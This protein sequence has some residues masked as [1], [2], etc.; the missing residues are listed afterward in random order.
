MIL[1]RWALPVLALVVMGLALT[2]VT[3]RYNARSLFIKSEQLNFQAQELDIAWRHLL[4]ARAELAR[5]ARIDQMARLNVGL[6]SA[7][8]S[9]TIYI[10]GQASV[11]PLEPELLP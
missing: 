8:L 11:L 6:T 7:D 1:R 10:Q 9:R 3:N 2:L 4:S 5:N